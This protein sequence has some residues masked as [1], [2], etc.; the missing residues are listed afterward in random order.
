MNKFIATIKIEVF[1]DHVFNADSLEDALQKSRK[2][3]PG[4]LIRL[5][6]KRDGIIDWDCVDVTSVFSAD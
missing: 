6:N 4:D 2:F 3:N 5:K 1:V